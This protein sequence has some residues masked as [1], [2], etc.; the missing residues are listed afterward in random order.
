[1]KIGIDM[2]ALQAPGT[3][4]RGIGRYLFN[5]LSA[6]LD[7]DRSNHYYLY[8]YEGLAC[9]EWRAARNLTCRVLPVEWSGGRANISQSLERLVQANPD[10]LDLFLVPSPLEGLSFHAHRPPARPLHGLKLG[11]ILHDFIPFLFQ[12]AYLIRPA[13]DHYYNILH[14]LGHYDFFLANSDATRRDSATFWPRATSR[15]FTIGGP[16][17]DRF[18]VP[19]DALTPDDASRAVLARFGITRPFVFNV[20]GFDRRKNWQGLIESF[21]LLSDHL[22]GSHQLVLTFRVDDSDAEIVRAHARRHGVATQLRLTRAVP[23]ADLRVLYQRCAAFVSPS[24]Y[25]GF[26]LPILEAM[27]C[28]APVIVAANSSQPEVAGNAGLLFDADDP[29]DLACQLRRLLD[30]KHLAVSMRQR[31]LAQAK[32]FQRDIIAERALDVLEK[33]VTPAR[34]AGPSALVARSGT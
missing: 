7:R 11:A 30:D 25:E 32:K 10:Q 23:D 9:E 16:T 26:G 33:I 3:R 28:G 18:F 31:S 22:R 27:S 8:Y 13:A 21:G 34:V 17:D 15:V 29:A 12:E 20:G 24:F 5:L 6:L 2:V 1:M 4:E 19:A 14:T